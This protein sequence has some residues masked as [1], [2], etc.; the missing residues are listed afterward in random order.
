MFESDDDREKLL[1]EIDIGEQEKEALRNIYKELEEFDQEIID[2]HKVIE[3]LNEK[4]VYCYEKLYEVIE[5][6]NEMK[7]P[8]EQSS[9]VSN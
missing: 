8:P 7:L 4:I 6:L 3:C 2:E 1:D 5:R 9:G